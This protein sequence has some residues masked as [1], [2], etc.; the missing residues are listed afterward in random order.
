MTTVV[1]DMRFF[2]SWRR[3][4][5]VEGQR[6]SDE[7]S[8]G[9]GALD[10]HGYETKKKGRNERVRGAKKGSG[11]TNGASNCSDAARPSPTVFQ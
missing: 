11:G 3:I 1:L 7:H 8:G 2:F 9:G 4:I 10:L 6:R 5:G